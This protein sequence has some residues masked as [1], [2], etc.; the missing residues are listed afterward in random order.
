[1][2][3][4]PFF[5]FI[6]ASALAFASACG[7]DTEDAGG[8]G[9][10]G[11]PS[12]GGSP[13]DGGGGNPSEG[14]GG[15]PTEGGG[16]SG[17]GGVA[18]GGA[19]GEG[20]VAEGGAGGEGGAGEGG[21][22]GSGPQ[23]PSDQIAAVLATADGAGLT[24]SIDGGLVTYVKPVAVGQDLPGFFLQAE[25]AGPAVFVAVD[26][27]TLTPAPVVGDELDLTVT[28]VG[29]ITGLKQVLAVS[30]VSVATSGNDI[31][32][33]V[34]DVS[35][36]TDLVTNLDGYSARAISL[37][38]DIAGPFVSAGAPQVA[39]PISTTGMVGDPDLRLRMPETV[40][41]ALDLQEGCIVE[42]DYGVMWRFNTTAQP[43]TVDAADLFAICDAPTVVS[44]VPAS[45]T[46]LQITFSRLLDPASV[47]ANGSQFTFSNGLTA[48]AA[49][50]SGNTVTVTT[51]A[52]T[53]GAMYT[54]TVDNTVEDNLGETLDVAAD[55]ADFTGYLTQAVVRINE[56]NAAITDGCDLMELRVVSGGVMDGFTVTE[57]TTTLATFAGLTVATG[58]IILLHLDGSDVDCN[59][60]ASG[61]ET[62]A[63]DQNPVLTFGAN[64]DVAWDW[65]S[66]DTGLTDTDNVFQVKDA[67]GTILDAVLAA[68]DNTSDLSA[69]DSE[70]A[71]ADAAMAG[72]WVM[73]GGGIPA[74]GFVN[75]AFRTWAVVD[76]DGTGTDRA[77]ESI[78][79]IDNTDDN[80]MADWAQGASSWG[81]LNAGQ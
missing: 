67:L 65:Y 79:R 74:G 73:V 50:A 53:A 6:C 14:G 78:R 52:Q 48:T 11:T 10:G 42:L 71:A 81:V 70:T 1:M 51:S 9:S 39:A 54:V 35:A 18:E 49:V 56:F 66:T 28:E 15:N 64:V 44:A 17:T 3:S 4:S 60:G 80:D 32:P 2:R 22:G 26:P 40:R 57:R 63:K 69:L 46:E 29:T 68:D 8:G 61:N 31:T 76:L 23:S 45:G 19:G 47:L 7:D 58:D 41:A 21:T 37:T 13:S 55:T 33:L 30:G 12:D 34:L 62:A 59:P 72:Q 75:L 25:Q 36:A 77:G 38:A 20:G 16:G 43:S 27:A 5:I 24:L